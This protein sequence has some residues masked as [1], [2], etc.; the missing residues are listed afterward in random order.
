M[1]VLSGVVLAAGESR[2]MKGYIK[3][4]LT[5]QG[6]TL[7]ERIIDNLKKSDIEE[8]FVVLGSHYSQIM[9]RVRLE[10]VMVLINEHWKSGQLSS[11]R[12]AVENLSHGSDGMLFTLADHPLVKTETYSILIDFWKMD[13]KRI[14]IPTSGGRKGHPAIFP[15]SVYSVLLNTELPHG[16][17]D[18]IYMK[19]D[20]VSS[21]EVADTGVVEDI[22]TI[23]DYRRL[24]GE[25]K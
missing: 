7:L 17:R 21:I 3:P 11:L 22:D 6:I 2:R 5:I 14:V 8:I 9:E 23:D 16:A 24:I 19:R 15:S 13:K 4:L 10:G 18:I 20:I 25:P 1:G 12:L